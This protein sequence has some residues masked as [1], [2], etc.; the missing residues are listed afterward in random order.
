MYLQAAD[1][2]TQLQALN[3]EKAEVAAALEALRAEHTAAHETAAEAASAAAQA[4]S[5]A[6]AQKASLEEEI[7]GLT[8]T[9]DETTKYQQE[10]EGTAVAPLSGIASRRNLSEHVLNICVLQP[11]R[12]YCRS[13]DCATALVGC[14]IFLLQH[15][16]AKIHPD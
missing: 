10:L 13:A 12:Q 15:D 8:A 16:Q 14:N 11:S 7:A 1:L 3:G 6:Q 5:Q 2:A 4:L 9:A